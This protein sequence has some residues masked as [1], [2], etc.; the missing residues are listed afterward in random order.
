MSFFPQLFK[1]SCGA[2]FGGGGGGTK[3]N[4]MRHSFFYF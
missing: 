2:F 3:E 1:K 4:T